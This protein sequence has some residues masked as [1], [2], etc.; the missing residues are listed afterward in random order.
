MSCNTCITV[1][2][3]YLCY[4]TIYIAKAAPGTPYMVEITNTGSGR[5]I[6]QEVI[7]DS[8]GFLLLEDGTWNDFFN[9]GSEFK[10]KIYH[11]NNQA[12]P[13]QTSNIPT[14]FNVI[15][16]FE[17]NYGNDMTVSETQYD[18][19]NVEFEMMYNDG[20]PESFD[21]Q[22]LINEDA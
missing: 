18:C 19:I 17:D 4:E 5:K 6:T 3:V 2:P 9:S 10:I 15:T 1:C 7:A 21:V 11:I 12:V 22:Y 20:V 8:E 14:D 16:G 13:A